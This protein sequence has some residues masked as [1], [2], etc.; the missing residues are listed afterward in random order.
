MASD[1]V[2][3]ALFEGPSP[4]RTSYT[5][6]EIKEKK[7]DAW[8][9]VG[10]MAVVG[11]AIGV[12]LGI[13]GTALI[14]ATGINDIEPPP[15]PA[16]SE[17]T[18]APSPEETPSPTPTPEPTEEEEGVEGPATLTTDNTS[19]GLGER[20]VLTG[21]F[22]EAGAGALLQVQIKDGDEPWD[23][24]PVTTRTD[25]QGGFRTIVR[26]SN[27]GDRDF[28]LLHE[29]SGDATPSVTITIG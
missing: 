2:S 29:D 18:A 14:R 24:F 22:E 4:Q 10:R 20:I 9:L 28:R 25:D 13:G 27:G 6:D 19:A 3:T 8:H 12:V 1:F 11:L 21:T 15:S 17:P 23:D 5:P 26:T 16:T 7:R